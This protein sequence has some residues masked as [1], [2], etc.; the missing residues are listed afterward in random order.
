MIY[1]QN[2]KKG[3]VRRGSERV[4]KGDDEPLPAQAKRRV[5]DVSE[6]TPQSIEKQAVRPQD[7]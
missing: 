2:V 1:A 7:N 3:K 4:A 6:F 5:E